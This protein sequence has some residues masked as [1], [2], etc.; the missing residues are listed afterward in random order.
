MGSPFRRLLIQKFYMNNNDIFHLVYYFNYSVIFTGSLSSMS[1]FKNINIVKQISY[2][3]EGSPLIAILL[4][5]I[6]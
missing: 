2:L 1:V 4:R 3:N 5:D 6:C